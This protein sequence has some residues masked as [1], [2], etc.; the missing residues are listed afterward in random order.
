MEAVP[1]PCANGMQTVGRERG[2]EG[3]SWGGR[4]VSEP[5][6]GIQFSLRQGVFLAVSCREEEGVSKDANV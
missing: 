4:K 5:K 3:H 6:N 2:M 1:C